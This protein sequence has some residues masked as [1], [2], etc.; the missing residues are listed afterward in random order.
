MRETIKEIQSKT[1]KDV[2][3]KLNTHHKCLL[4]RPT[5]F[6]KTKTSVDIIKRYKHAVF[7]YPFNNI[8]NAV[9]RYDI[10]G[11]DLH[12]Y[13]YSKIRNIFKNRS[14]FDKEFSKFDLKNTI[15]VMD[16]AHFIGAGGTEKIIKALMDEVCPKANYLGITATPKRT[17]KLDIKWHF[18]DGITAYEYGL[19]EAFEDGIYVKPYYVYTPLD[20]KL[21]DAILSKIDNSSASDAKKESMKKDIIKKINPSKLKIENLHE[22]I[23]RNLYKFENEMNYYKFILFFS[24]FNDIHKKKNEIVSAFEKVFPDCEVNVVIVSSENA[25]YRM[26]LNVIDDLAVRENTVD[27]IFNVNMLTFGYHIDNISGIM[28]FRQTVSNII[29]TQQ[30]GR[31]L[32]VIQNT[33]AIIFD[34]VENLYKFS[35]DSVSSFDNANGGQINMLEPLL[36]L[37]CVILDELSE[38]LLNIDRLINNAITEE[39]E[40]EVVN[41]YKMELVDIDYC[42][43]KLQLQNKEDF[44]K[45]LERYK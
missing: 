11:L 34:F 39:F 36:P 21:E 45:V 12:L 16:E 27:L 7:L 6:G 15:F 1:I 33:S 2:M 37:D 28:M 25:R 29:Y 19:T 20:D 40:E 30:I 3:K 23:E 18:F 4:I 35:P 42:V 14:Y 8:G 32:S 10:E 9:K 43:T 31:C 17:D 41:A 24:T 5:G 26:N 38:E 44:N 22:I 13:T